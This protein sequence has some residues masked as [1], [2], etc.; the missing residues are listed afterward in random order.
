MNRKKT[1]KEVDI[2]LKNRLKIVKYVCILLFIILY[3]ATLRR[4]L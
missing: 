2:L 1:F 3:I 4:H